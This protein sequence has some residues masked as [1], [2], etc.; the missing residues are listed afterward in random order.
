LEN[1]AVKLLPQVIEV[2]FREE[3][4]HAQIL[5]AVRQR[6]EMSRNKMS[7]RYPAWAEMEERFRAYIKPTAGDDKRSNL[8]KDGKTQFTT[9]EIPYSYAILLTLHTYL[10]SVFLGRTPIFQY[11][12]RHGESQESVKGVEALI[13]YQRQVGEWLV[14]LYIWL[15]DGPKYGLGIIGS[16]WC[17]EFVVTTE[18]REEPV[19]YFGLKT[20]KTR[21]VRETKRI[22]GYK[23][24]KLFNVRPQD[25]YPDPRVSI[26]QFQTGEFCGRR[27]EVGWNTI[28]K[29]RE[30][31][32]FY[33]VDELR[34]K[35]KTQGNT[36]ETGSSQLILPE[37]MDTLY[38]P[39]SGIKGEK[40]A[41]N[42]VE[43]FE[44]E[45]ELIPREW[46]F[47]KSETPEKWVIT[48]A[49]DAVIMSVEPLGLLHDKF[50]YD[51]QEYEIEGYA[52]AKRSLL[53]ILAPL[54]NTLSWL[55]N[56]HMHNVRRVLN[57]QLIV[58]PSGVTMKDLTDPDA[59][60][61]VRLKPEAYGKDPKTFIHQLQIIDIT[62]NHMRD[63]G[64]IT[65]MMQRISGVVNDVMGATQGSS[66]RTATEVRT[67]SGFSMNR[68]KTNTEYA[69]AMGFQPLSQKLLQTT[70]QKYDG[71]QTFKIAG[72]LMRM[73]APLRVT[74]QMIAGAYDF[75][76]VDGTM[77]VDRY[78]QAMLWKELMSVIASGKVIDPMTG[79]P[80]AVDL[81]GMLKHI[82]YLS[83]VKNFSQF[84]IKVSPDAQ[85]G[86][87]VRAGNLVPLPGPG[88]GGG[89]RQGNSAGGGRGNS[90]PQQIGQLG[91]VPGVGRAA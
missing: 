61:L 68:M 52:L 89:P 90:T 48:T 16:H 91:S 3:K 17:E 62:Q 23:G 42:F 84:E 70:Q 6:R 57:D 71:E 22:P 85:I 32:R 8:R 35:M 82:A 60:R 59:G 53:E 76:A 39:G 4:R 18:S 24:N 36:R 50:T 40:E 34:N 20:M 46:G 47:S 86:A 2:P 29:R 75:V 33:N 63:A 66:R 44:L 43:L 38:S 49:N 26:A 11:E 28:L 72:D 87:D 15:M 56:S 73:A 67:N 65:E 5:E 30:E 77:P 79:Q 7:E 19:T 69:S 25:W 83:G 37:G 64:L 21:V 74:P 13:D 12:G 55:V 31:G 58:D 14:P 88:G 27:L 1:S 81:M 54:N 41:K 9:I 45:I 80:P 78:A 51:V 10:S